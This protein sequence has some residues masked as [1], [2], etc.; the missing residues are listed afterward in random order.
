MKKIFTLLSLFITAFCFGQ[1]TFKVR[2]F[3]NYNSSLQQVIQLND[4][5]FV[6]VGTIVYDPVTTSSSLYLLKTDN[7]GNKLASKAVNVSNFDV[8]SSVI[9]TS[10]GGLVISG[11]SDSSILIMKLD[12]S[13][14]IQWQNQYSVT[15]SGTIAVNKIL[16]T[17]DGGYLLAGSKIENSTDS[18]GVAGCLLKIDATGSLVF[19]KRY[20]DY[21]ANNLFDVAAT[22]DGNYALLGGTQYDYYTND[23]A[24][25]VKINPDGSVIWVRSLSNTNQTTHATALLSA[26]DSGIVV[27]GESYEIDSI[28]GTDQTIMVKYSTAGNL[29]WSQAIATGAGTQN[30]AY[31]VTEDI[32]SGYVF[33]GELDNFKDSGRND[34]T[35]GYMVKTNAAGALQWTK[36]F[37]GDSLGFT[38]FNNLIKTSDGG[39][40][41][42]GEGYFF[43]DTA[44]L[45]GSFLY[46]FNSNFQACNEMIGTAGAI[47]NFGTTAS[48]NNA[49]VADLA[50]TVTSVT[51]SMSDTA[52]IQNFCSSDVL[53]VHLLSFNAAL[54][55]KVVNIEWKTTNEINTDHFIVERSGNGTAFSALQKVIAK[56]SN[57]SVENY[58]TT[59]LQP[60]TG[61]SYYR[62]QQV[63]KSGAVTYS[64]I[65][66]ITVLANGTIVISPNPVYNN[67]RVVMKS[68]TGA[69][70]TFQVSDI[71]GRL[72]TTQTQRVGEGTNTINI[73][74]ASLSKGVYLLK[75]IQD[76]TMQSIKFIKR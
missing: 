59:D 48:V 40:V 73:P 5:S 72:L 10:D 13:L 32:D 23:S 75:V 67:I 35:Y 44:Y 64:N 47:Q 27:T 11:S 51:A 7:L 49:T 52:T 24:Y 19:A 43:S 16:Q 37:E 33:A 68:Q 36:T 6:S 56:G 22:A 25:I 76:K 55:N 20:F 3:S 71:N 62:L 2:S 54:Q 14:S 69:N 34:S 41:A 1:N 66:A 50:I 45:D 12:A 42:C 4:G 58:T 9:K 57:S 28:S 21:N 70:T 61:T 30:Y 31:A 17:P 38:Q 8:G 63:D 53:P 39:Y 60:L 15:D 46:K 26:L 18:N 74:A 65:V 29:V